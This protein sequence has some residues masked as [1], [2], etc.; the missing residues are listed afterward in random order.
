MRKGVLRNFANF[1]GKHL[2][3]SLCFNKVAGLTQT[4]AQ[5]FSS[6]FGEISKSTFSYRKPPMATS[7]YDDTSEFIANIKNLFIC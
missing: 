1:I 5:A 6:D 2:C 7:V 4:L 3:Q